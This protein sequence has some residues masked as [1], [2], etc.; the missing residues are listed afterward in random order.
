MKLVGRVHQPST[1]HFERSTIIRECGTILRRAGRTFTPNQGTWLVCHCIPQ[2]SIVRLIF[3]F[4]ADQEHIAVRGVLVWKGDE[5]MTE[6][7]PKERR[8]Y[9]RTKVA[10]PIEFKAEGATVASHAET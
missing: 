1:C 4:R 6:Q 3:P 9:P 8:R 2:S 10:I 7:P 5:A